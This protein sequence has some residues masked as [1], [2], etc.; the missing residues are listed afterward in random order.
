MKTL[1]QL[2]EKSTSERGGYQPKP[3]DEKRFVDK[4]VVVKTQDANGNKDDVFNASNV[5]PVVRKDEGHGYE[6]GDDVAVYEAKMTPA[7][8]KQRE[9]IV[10]GMK[11]NVSSFK[12]RYGKDAKTVMYATATK[13]A[14][15]EEVETLSEEDQIVEFINQFYD[16]LTDENKQI[17]EELTEE[18]DVEEILSMIDEV[19]SGED[20]G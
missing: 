5:K 9:R 19:L 2:L 10:K 8:M 15:E 7:D 16:Q 4:H 6:P 3:K 18:Q 13:K 1:K 11:K 14:M 12:S 20:N 17:F